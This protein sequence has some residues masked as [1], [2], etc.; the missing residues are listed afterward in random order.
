M[1]IH[2]VQERTRRSN[3][4]QEACNGF[5]HFC[6]VSFQGG[7]FQA[8][9]FFLGILSFRCWM[10]QDY[11]SSSILVSDHRDNSKLKI[12]EILHD[13]SHPF[14]VHR[15]GSVFHSCTVFRCLLCVSRRSCSRRKEA[16]PPSSRTCFSVA[17]F[18]CA[19]LCS[20]V[21]ISAWP[22]FPLLPCSMWK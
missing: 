10:F 13:T 17:P 11:I 7:F 19:R 3:S 22:S 8:D 12:E 4:K 6:M 16:A 2:K 9:D 21:Q 15:R 5:P 18:F 1:H 14:S 20:L